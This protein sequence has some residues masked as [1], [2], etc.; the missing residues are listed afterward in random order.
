MPS[1]CRHDRLRE[2]ETTFTIEGTDVQYD[3]PARE[4][5]MRSQWGDLPDARFFARQADIISVYI[6]LTE[7]TTRRVSHIGMN[8]GIFH[9][10]EESGFL[11]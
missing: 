10:A 1:C 11:R 7:C 2:S 6:D 5:H 3:C 9:F 4:D 8:H